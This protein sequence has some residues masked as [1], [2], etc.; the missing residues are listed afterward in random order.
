[1]TARSGT[2]PSPYVGTRRRGAYAGA[3][4]R[5]PGP[6]MAVPLGAVRVG[7][8]FTLGAVV[9]G[10]L[11]LLAVLSTVS[12][13][14]RLV[15][16]HAT[17]VMSNSMAPSLYTG[18]IVITSPVSG[19]VEPGDVIRFADPARPDRHILHRVVALAADGTVLTAGDANGAA[20]SAAVPVAGIDGTLRLHVPGLGLPVIWARDDPGTAAGVAVALVIALLL[21]RPLARVAT[22]GGLSRARRLRRIAGAATAGVTGV[23]VMLTLG[24]QTSSAAFIAQTTNPANGFAAGTVTL[25]DDD[26]GNSPSTGSAMFAVSGLTSAAPP[27]SRCITVTYT[28]NVAAPVKLYSTSLSGTGLGTYLN[29]TV[30][31]GTAASAGAYAGCGGFVLGTTLYNGTL[32]G[33]AGTHT[34]Y[35][36]GLASDWTPTTNGHQRVFRITY[37]LQ[38]NPAAVG[39]ACGAVL[40]WEAQ[41]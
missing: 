12:V 18:D 13:A 22:R 6:A 37:S 5:A 2:A 4:R 40:V 23:A 31:V 10:A 41:G 24:W 27:T 28:G 29:L 30:D 1:M 15:G 11:A 39:L 33:Y 8:P 38:N 20:D 35:A 16:W 21:L 36:A 19:P 3:R 7:V 32:A 14:P 25:S 26:G 34:S 9:M 17:T